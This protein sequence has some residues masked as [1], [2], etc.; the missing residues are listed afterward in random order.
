MSPRA[1]GHEAKARGSPFRAAVAARQRRRG[2]GRRVGSSDNINYNSNSKSNSQQQ[3]GPGATGQ[4]EPTFAELF[5]M[6]SGD[7]PAA[8]APGGGA[9]GANPFGP[10]PGGDPNA[11]P[12]AALLKGM[13]GGAGPGG[14]APPPQKATDAFFTDRLPVLQRVKKVVLPAFFLF[15]FWRGYIGRWGLF[16]G[17]FSKSYFD[18][19]AVPLRVLPESPLVD[20]PYITCQVYVDLGARVLGYFINLARGK[21]KFPPEMPGMGGLPMKFPGAVQ[22]GA[23]AEASP[24]MPAGAPWLS[25]E[26]QAP[27]TTLPPPAPT[28]PVMAAS[29]PMAKPPSPSPPTPSRPGTGPPSRTPPT[30]VDADVTFL[31]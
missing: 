6:M 1:D 7:M 30:I 23:A 20:R 5:K 13:G 11:D 24:P 28:V 27:P 21:A 14:Q 4:R 2:A 18:M 26:D 17:C 16:M 10:G 8:G 22:N 29:V 31:D 25:W 19:L 12:L 3:T 9:A 15:C